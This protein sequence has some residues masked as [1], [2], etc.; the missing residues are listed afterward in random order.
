MKIYSNGK[1]L[2]VSG[3]AFDTYKEDEQLVGS[4]FSKPL[5]R[6][7]FTGTCPAA[8]SQWHTINA[9]T[10]AVVGVM[11]NSYVTSPS[12]KSMEPLPTLGGSGSSIAPTKIRFTPGIGLQMYNSGSWYVNRTTT[13]ILYYTK[14]SDAEA[15]SEIATVN[16]I[17][18]AAYDIHSDYDKEVSE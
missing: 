6:R 7:I 17:Q 13:A 18:T 11:L 10:E 9:F 16:E 12:D 8:D 5:Y 1:E 3:S 2:A 4:W 14:N 15:S